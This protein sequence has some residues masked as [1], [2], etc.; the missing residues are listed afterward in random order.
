[1]SS[2][3]INNH[4]LNKGTE[5][6]LDIKSSQMAELIIENRNKNKNY[7]ELP[8]NNY[9]Y[10]YVPRGTKL[11]VINI[12]KTSGDRDITFSTKY[13][14]FRVDENIL[15]EMFQKNHVRFL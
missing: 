12:I 9:G 1:M 14:W 2:I 6:K 3:R 10:K 4:T 8:E 13:G 11:Q 15:A 7:A 5:L